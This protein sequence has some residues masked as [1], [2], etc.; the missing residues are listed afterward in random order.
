SDVCSSDL[1]DERRR[2]R[3]A[4]DGKVLHGSLGLRA[5]IHVGRNAHFAQGVF[6]GAF[7]KDGLNGSF[8]LHGGT[9]ERR[10]SSLKLGNDRYFKCRLSVLSSGGVILLPG[11]APARGRYRSGALEFSYIS[12]CSPMTSL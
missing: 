1:V 6:S 10:S 12:L 5:V 8:L 4:T 3:L 9:S 11:I 7:G 2:Q